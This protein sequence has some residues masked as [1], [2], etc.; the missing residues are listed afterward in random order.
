MEGEGGGSKIERR[1][2]FSCNTVS[3]GPTGTSRAKMFFRD[4]LTGGQMTRP[5][6]HSEISQGM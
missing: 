1:E 2:R 5:G 4:V 3:D 6:Y